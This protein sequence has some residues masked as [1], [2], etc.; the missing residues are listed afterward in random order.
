MAAQ[1][2]YLKKLLEDKDRFADFVNVNVFHGKQVLTSADLIQLPNE[3]GIVVIDSDGTKRTIER[4]RDPRNNAVP[5]L[6]K[7]DMGWTNEPV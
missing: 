4:R 3:S 7:P 6:R 1:D 5:I 2:Y